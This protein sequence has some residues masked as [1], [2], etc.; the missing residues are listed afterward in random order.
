LSVFEGAALLQHIRGSILQ[1]QG[2]A[3]LEAA[4]PSLQGVPAANIM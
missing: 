1:Q 4:L 2:E 3:Q